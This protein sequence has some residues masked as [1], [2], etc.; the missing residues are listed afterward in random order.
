MLAFLVPIAFIFGHVGV[1]VLSPKFLAML[2][3]HVGVAIV[4]SIVPAVVA[5][6]IATAA[7]L[8]IALPPA[9]SAAV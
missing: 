5:P 8:A 4:I 6:S 3:S 2:A 9:A 1:G 7:S